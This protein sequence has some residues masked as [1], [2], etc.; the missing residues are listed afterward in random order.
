M[1]KLKQN[2]L[3]YYYDKVPDNYKKAESFSEFTK[4]VP[5]G[6]DFIDKLNIDEPFLIGP[7]ESGQ[8]EQYN[9]NYHLTEQKIRPYL[10]RGMVFIIK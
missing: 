6:K 5:T 4:K 8:Y 10:K 1:S 2:D 3:G 9:I 7:N